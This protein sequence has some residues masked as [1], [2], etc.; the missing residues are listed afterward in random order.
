MTTIALGLLVIRC[1][2]GW[3][4]GNAAQ[5][6]GAFN[7]DLSPSQRTWSITQPIGPVKGEN[8]LQAF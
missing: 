2:L 5:Y 1:L 6:G 8:A 3:F 4:H 7:G